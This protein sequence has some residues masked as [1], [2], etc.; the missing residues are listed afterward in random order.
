VIKR[1]IAIICGLFLLATVAYA[2]WYSDPPRQT[3]IAVIDSGVDCSL[4]TCVPG[5]DF[6]D[7]DNTPFSAANQHGTNTTGI[8]AD[9]ATNIQIML[10]EAIVAV[11]S[12]GECPFVHSR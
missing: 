8:L 12:E 7:N 4:F 2:Q 3:V 1:P 5:W 10:D 9:L 11:L 6:V